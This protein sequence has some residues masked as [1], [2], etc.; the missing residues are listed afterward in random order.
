MPLELKVPVADVSI[1]GNPPPLIP[2]MGFCAPVKVGGT[3]TM[4]LNAR[5]VCPFAEAGV[6]PPPSSKTLKSITI[7][8]ETANIFLMRISSVYKVR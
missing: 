7:T 5:M 2:R 8:I 6:A 1:Q 4:V 3:P